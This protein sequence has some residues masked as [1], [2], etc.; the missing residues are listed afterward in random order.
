[1][2][3][4][5][6]KTPENISGKIVIISN[7]IQ[8]QKA[9]GRVDDDDACLSV[10]PG[11]DPFRE[12]DVDLPLSP[13]HDQEGRAAGL[14]DPGDLADLG[15]VRG[16]DP[17]AEELEVVEAVRLEP[18]E[19]ARPHEHF[20]AGQGVRRGQR[21]DPLELQEGGVPVPPERFDGPRLEPA[22]PLDID[23]RQVEPRSLLLLEPELDRPVPSLAADD[24]AKDDEISLFR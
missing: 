23:R 14:E 2:T 21:I 18:S 17:A 22:V 3:T 9:V 16:D 19:S 5:P 11:H 4:P 24:P 20:A 12:R 6:E 10:D 7:L 15:P 8:V 13:L 1:L